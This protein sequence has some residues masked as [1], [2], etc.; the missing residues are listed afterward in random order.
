MESEVSSYSRELLVRALSTWKVDT[1]GGQDE[2]GTY[3]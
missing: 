2:V 3:L 1:G